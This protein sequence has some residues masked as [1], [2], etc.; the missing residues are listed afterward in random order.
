MRPVLIL[1]G[2]YHVAKQ[3]AQKLHIPNEP[4]T[5][6]YVSRRADVYGW[7]RGVAVLLETDTFRQC[8]NG[9]ELLVHLN[10]HGA[11]VMRVSLDGLSG[12]IR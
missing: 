6:H 12:V 8:P 4:R 3:L 7:G 1:A 11:Q 2:S 9:L 5:W 10:S